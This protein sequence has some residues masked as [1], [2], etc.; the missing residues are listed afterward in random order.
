MEWH[1]SEWRIFP[2]MNILITMKMDFDAE[3]E[4]MFRKEND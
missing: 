2:N 4:A 1:I 3:H